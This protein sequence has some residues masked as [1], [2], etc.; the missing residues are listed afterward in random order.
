MR[1]RFVSCNQTTLAA[2][3]YD[4]PLESYV[5]L[6]ELL[7]TSQHWC[8]TYRQKAGREMCRDVILEEPR[9]HQQHLDLVVERQLKQKKQVF[10]VPS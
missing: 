1:R 4:S 7:Q 6:S 8:Q 5:F 10:F 9:T 2:D 3:N